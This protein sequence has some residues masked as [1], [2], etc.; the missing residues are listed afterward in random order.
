MNL[1]IG[2]HVLYDWENWTYTY[3]RA[4][5]YGNIY[6][7]VNYISGP[8]GYQQ[9]RLNHLCKKYEWYPEFINQLE[10]VQKIFDDEV[11]NKNFDFLDLEK[12]KTYIDNFLL[13]Y[14]DKI[15]NLIIFA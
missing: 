6:K 1:I 15:N 7:N 12:T 2:K 9:I 14:I 8:V 10:F 13:K 5:Y 3:V 11:M 4:F